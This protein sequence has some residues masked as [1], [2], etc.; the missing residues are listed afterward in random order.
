MTLFHLRNWLTAV[1]TVFYTPFRLWREATAPLPDMLGV[2]GP[3]F[4]QDGSIDW[5]NGWITPPEDKN[6]EAYQ[7][8]GWWLPPLV[9]DACEEENPQ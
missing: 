8:A 3:T 7:Y 5:G 6:A 9:Q 4:Y 1:C 2:T